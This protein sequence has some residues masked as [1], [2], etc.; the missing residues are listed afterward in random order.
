MLD[1][2]LV[3]LDGSALAERALD[4]AQP[5]AC[6]SRARLVLLRVA[7][8]LPVESEARDYVAAKAAAL[9]PGLP[10][11]EP[12]VA[13]IAKGHDAAE[14]I[15]LAI[16]E[17]ARDH[18]AGLVVMSTHGRGGLG[19]WMYGSVADVALRHGG[20]PLLLVP[21]TCRRAWPGGRPLRVLVPLDGSEA[22]EA[23]LGPV[24]ELADTVPVELHLVQ[25]VETE[26][27][28]LRYGAAPGVFPI[29]DP[30]ADER[31]ARDY[32]EGVAA[33]LRERGRDVR[34]H[35]AF[36][37]AAQVI[38]L[39]ARQQDVDLVA[40]ATHGRGGM[41]RAVL[42]SVA[43]QT[44]QAATAP[45]LVVRPATAVTAEVPTPPEP[46]A[47]AG[48]AAIVS[49][50]E[51]ERAAVER[52]LRTLVASERDPANLAAARRILS[53]LDEV[54]MEL[55]IAGAELGTQA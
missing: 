19:R 24:E 7:T 46:Q 35:T 22:G 4:Y 48:D 31:E 36:D 32:L 26:A 39:V 34:V 16:L 54:A 17:A 49:L 30:E 43:T 40:M 29:L 3:P 21:A 27:Y 33:R 41:A 38:D 6:L 8:A 55:R 20:T 45:V 2:I 1:T 23:A 18:G 14:E 15:G 10:T 28:A 50:G 37:F 47:A 25:A 44:L 9:R 51:A 53:R 11:T 52:G 5:L 12:A 42:G 13:Y